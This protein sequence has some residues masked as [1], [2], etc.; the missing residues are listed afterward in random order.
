MRSYIWERI[1]KFL[2]EN[3]YVTALVLCSE[4][5]PSQPASKLIA[6]GNLEV[7]PNTSVPSG[8]VLSILQTS[9]QGDP[10][11][12]SSLGIPLSLPVPD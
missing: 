8:A 4:T 3:A 9:Y 7:P 11:S 10:E 2:K 12:E 5:S 1:K 6:S